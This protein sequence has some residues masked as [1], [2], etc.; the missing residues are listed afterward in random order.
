MFSADSRESSKV[1][2]K[3]LDILKFD[4]IVSMCNQ[5]VASEITE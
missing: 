3:L 5:M 1:F 2:Y 4:N